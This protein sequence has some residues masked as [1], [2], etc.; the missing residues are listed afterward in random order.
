MSYSRLI[1]VFVTFELL[2]SERMEGIVLVFSLKYV[3]RFLVHITKI[4][5][6]SINDKFVKTN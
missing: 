5:G 3:E 2:L 4:I 1:E 6:G